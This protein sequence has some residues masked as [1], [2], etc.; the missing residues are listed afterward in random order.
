MEGGGSGILIEEE[1]LRRSSEE[2][3]CGSFRFP[4]WEDGGA[5]GIFREEGFCSSDEVGAWG[6]WMEEGSFSRSFEVTCWVAGAPVEGAAIVL[7]KASPAWGDAFAESPDPC[8]LTEPG[9][10]PR[11]A[12]LS[13]PV[14]AL[15][16]VL[17]L[18]ASPLRSVGPP[19]PPELGLGEV[20]GPDA[21]EV[22][23]AEAGVVLGARGPVAGPN[24]TGMLA[25][26]GGAA[27]PSVPPRTSYPGERRPGSLTVAGTPLMVLAL[28]LLKVGIACV[29]GT[30]LVV[31][32]AW[33]LRD[34]SSVLPPTRSS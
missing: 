27:P 33:A 19:S 30:L 26:E 5:S 4:I 31:S 10:A 17:E 2:G 15:S 32:G 28:P 20:G 23:G 9:A 14:P 24:E 16:M 21:L 8:I 1:G 7:S 34:S 6:S 13:V 29:G 11:R 22:A 25:L 3:A 18:A 12:G